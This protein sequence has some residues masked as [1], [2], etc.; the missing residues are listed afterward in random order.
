LLRRRQVLVLAAALAVA[1]AA[2]GGKARAGTL[3]VRH[4]PL[5]LTDVGT[6]TSSNW[7]GYA[8]S[9]TGTGASPTAFSAVAGSWVQ[10][11]ATCAAGGAAYAAF[12]VGLGGYVDGSQGL[13]QTG[14]EADCSLGGAASYS[15]WYELLPA[16]PVPVRLKVRPGDRISASVAVN[17]TRVTIK[18]R[19]VTR[20]TSFAKVL[21]KRAPDTSSAEWIAEAPS[22]CGVTGCQTLPLANFGT[23]SFSGATTIGSAHHGVISD[24]AWAVTA[25]TLHGGGPNALHG[26]FVGNSPD[27]DALPST[28]GPDGTS[29]SV[30][31]Q[32][33]PPSSG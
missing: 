7:S 4:A 8:V 24:P 33:H 3:A 19:N 17:G 22:T 6:T 21:R 27:A 12:W 14:T 32:Q 31:W 25:V 2:A 18:L 28:L 29:F 20:R 13:E 15:M 11:A 10:P 26:R 9:D 1:L 5:V 16:P 30:A 23:V